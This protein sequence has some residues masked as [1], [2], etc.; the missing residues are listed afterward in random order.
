MGVRLQLEAKPS[1]GSES[2][3][4]LKEKGEKSHIGRS[5]NRTTGGITPGC[6]CSLISIISTSKESL[7]VSIT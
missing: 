1:D 2:P 7:D 3:G 4:W 5:F 6:N